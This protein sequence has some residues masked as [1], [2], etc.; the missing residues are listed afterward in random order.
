MLRLRLARR[1]FARVQESTRGT[2][3]RDGGVTAEEHP[4]IQARRLGLFAEYDFLQ[5]GW[6]FVH[7]VRDLPTQ[8]AGIAGSCLCGHWA[9]I[10]LGG[11]G[12]LFGE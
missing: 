7:R 9:G 6:S 8:L 5:R 2:S 11:G 4:A 3:P 12:K 10:A 1:G